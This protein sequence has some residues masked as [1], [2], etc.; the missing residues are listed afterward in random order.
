MLGTGTNAQDGSM[1]LQSG[2]DV[3]HSADD[4]LGFQEF[5]PQPQNEIPRPL[6]CVVG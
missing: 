1:S 2:S 5:K 6:C 3:P 4:G